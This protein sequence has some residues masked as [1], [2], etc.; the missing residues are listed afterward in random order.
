MGAFI[1]VWLGWG[2]LYLAF[3][4]VPAP[5]G[6]WNEDRE[7]IGTL[8]PLM[9]AVWCIPVCTFFTLRRLVRDRQPATGRQGEQ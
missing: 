3:N 6:V 5:L 2:I 4:A 8:A 1:S 9:M 7:Q